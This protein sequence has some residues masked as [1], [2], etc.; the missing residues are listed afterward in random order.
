LCEHLLEEWQTELKR[1]FETFQKEQW[2]VKEKTVYKEF[3][4]FMKKTKITVHRISASSSLVEHKIIIHLFEKFITKN[5]K[6]W[7]ENESYL[8]SEFLQRVKAIESQLQEEYNEYRLNL[9]LKWYISAE[10][11]K[12]VKLIMNEESQWFKNLWRR[13]DKT[14]NCKLS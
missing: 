14:K 9:H 10:S 5:E 8:S 1:E 12:Y 13:A 2:K 4:K 7:L 6:Q 11:D 3:N